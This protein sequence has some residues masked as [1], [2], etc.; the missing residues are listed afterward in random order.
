MTSVVHQGLTNC[1]IC[2]RDLTK[3]QRQHGHAHCS[4][5]CGTVS[6]KATSEFYT[7]HRGFMRFAVDHPKD[8][9]L[10]FAWR[11]VKEGRK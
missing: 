2:A 10:R 1:R 9:D 6:M 4:R 3:K 5:R 11:D 7:G 8:G